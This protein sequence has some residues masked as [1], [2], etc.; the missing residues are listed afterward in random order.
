MAP[1]SVIILTLTCFAAA[2]GPGLASPLPPFVA[3]LVEPQATCESCPAC[4]PSKWPCKD[5]CCDPT[6]R[7]SHRPASERHLLRVPRLTLTLALAGWLRC[8][9]THRKEKCAR[10]RREAPRH[11]AASAATHPASATAPSV[12]SKSRAPFLCST[13]FFSGERA[14]AAAAVRPPRLTDVHRLAVC[15]NLAVWQHRPYLRPRRSP[16]GIAASRATRRANRAQLARTQTRTA[17]ANAEV[18]RDRRR[19]HQPRHRRHHPLLLLLPLPPRR[20]RPARQ[21]SAILTRGLR[22]FA[23]EAFPARSAASLPAPALLSCY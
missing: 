23:R 9:R 22:S 12:R 18:R 15:D 20:L 7:P 4:P 11:P 14:A 5:V 13:L 16:P 1:S 17:A 19:R 21:H 6:V 2:T 10:A 3:E 8:R